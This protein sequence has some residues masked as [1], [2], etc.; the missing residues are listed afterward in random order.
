[1][2]LPQ[3]ISIDIL[4]AAYESAF[5]HSDCDIYL[6][7]FDL[8]HPQRQK[9]NLRSKPG[10]RITR[11]TFLMHRRSAGVAFARQLLTMGIAWSNEHLQ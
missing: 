10:K 1:M 4:S 7:L 2:V 11:L 8:G 3:I 9:A 5:C 6:V